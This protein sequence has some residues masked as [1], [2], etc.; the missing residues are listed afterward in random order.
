MSALTQ[1]KL[2]GPVHTLRTEFAEWDIG[3]EEWQA[4]RHSSIVQFRPDGEVIEREDQNPN[5]S[6]SRS[7]FF[8]DDAGRLLE[9]E[10][11]LDE[12]PISKMVHRYDDSGRLMRKITVDGNGAESYSATYSYADSG[13]QRQ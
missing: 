6:V 3:Q 12:G 10:F 7:R 13:R 4:P 1:L 5:G 2:R 11:R 9:T 8:Y